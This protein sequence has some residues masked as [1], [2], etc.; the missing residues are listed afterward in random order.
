M[1]AI[2]DV[3]TAIATTLS[4]AFSDVTVYRH[5]PDALDA[6]AF[7]VG[8]ITVEPSTFGMDGEYLV[9]VHVAVSRRSVD[10]MD[11]LDDYVSFDGDSVPQAL[12]TDPTL[13][14]AVASVAVLSVGSYREL[15][16]E[17]GYYAATVKV[18]VFT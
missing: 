7:V 8:G 13:G 5:L 14:G 6:P 3:R 11:S 1:S 15:P 4:E 12:Q 9:E 16:I 10:L 2:G 18:Q 17:P